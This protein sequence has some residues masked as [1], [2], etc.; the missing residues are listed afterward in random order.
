M[1]YTKTQDFEARDDLKKK[2]VQFIP[3]EDLAAMKAKVAPI[4][5]EWSKKSPLIAEFV[6]VAQARP[7]RHA[8]AP[9][10]GG[11]ISLPSCRRDRIVRMQ[12]NALAP[13]IETIPLGGTCAFM[14]FLAGTS[15]LAI[16]V[17][18]VTQVYRA[19]CLQRIADLGR[20]ALPL[21]FDLA[22]LSF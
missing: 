18:M 16:V 6:A 3:L 21:H 14:R 13:S 4:I 2:G 12:T 15:M 9:A 10:S 11:R 5:G 17:I 19:L 1:T 8:C 7:D 22:E 20:G